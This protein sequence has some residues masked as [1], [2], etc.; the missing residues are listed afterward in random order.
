MRPFLSSRKN[1]LKV[2][3]GGNA[4]PAP[5]FGN[6]GERTTVVGGGGQAGG[7]RSAMAARRHMVRGVTMGMATVYAVTFLREGSSLPLKCLGSWVDYIES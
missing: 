2:I 4:T 7:R 3:F 1:F 6:G 5:V